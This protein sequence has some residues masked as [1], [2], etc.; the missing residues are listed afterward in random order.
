MRTGARG[1]VRPDLFFP[2]LSQILNSAGGSLHV[3]PDPVTFRQEAS[4][5]SGGTVFPIYNE[6]YLSDELVSEVLQIEEAANQINAWLIHPLSVARVLSDKTATR[7]AL[8]GIIPMPG[9]CSN[10]PLL[11]ISRTGTGEKVQIVPADKADP[12]LHNS[13]FIDTRVEHE[14]KDYYTSI[15]AMCIGPKHIVSFIRARPTSDQYPSVHARDTPLHPRMI[16]HLHETII[17]PAEAEIR[18]IC[19]KFGSLFGMGFYAIDLL[20]E[21][22]GRMLMCE[23]GFKL[24]DQNYIDHLSPIGALIPVYSEMFSGELAIRT[25]QAFV[26]ALSV[27]RRH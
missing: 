7:T 25:A 10:G 13:R 9:P 6:D 22:N 21:R 11:S 3:F 15:R 12:K 2:V 24:F 20:P 16:Q 26:D 8:A 23:A 5:F 18:E 27:A 4:K 17:I 14:G 19:D 1:K